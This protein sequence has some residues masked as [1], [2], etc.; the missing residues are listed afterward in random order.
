MSIA[1]T[2]T[3]P[4][5]TAQIGFWMATALV[6]GNMI[7]SG[8]FLLP[9]ALA[10]F[11][12]DNLPGWLLTAGGAIALGLVFAALSRAVPGAGGPYVYT[13]AAFGDLPGFTRGLGLL[14]VGLGRQRGDRHRRRRLRR[15]VLPVDGADPAD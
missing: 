2:S 1:P 8:I 11:G 12:A 10:P 15:R 7:G 6:V 5:K 13:R 3:P 4:R 14:G 9:A